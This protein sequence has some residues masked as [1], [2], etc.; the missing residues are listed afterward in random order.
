[1]FFMDASS[2]ISLRKRH[3]R[4]GALKMLCIMRP[5]PYPR[6]GCQVPLQHV[7]FVRVRGEETNIS[8]VLM[9]T[10]VP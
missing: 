6:S 8:I 7:P 1:M 2:S 10:G 3:Q 9:S 4:D 5:A